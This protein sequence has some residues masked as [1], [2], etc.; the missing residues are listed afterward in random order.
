MWLRGKPVPDKITVLTVLQEEIWT[1]DISLGS[2][3]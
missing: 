3:T 2:G 1:V